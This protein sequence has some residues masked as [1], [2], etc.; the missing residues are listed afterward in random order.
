[1]N[2]YMEA[3]I[4]L[5]QNTDYADYSTQT[6]NIVNEALSI[7]QD[8]VEKSIPLKVDK[9]E[10]DIDNSD[11]RWTIR[12]YFCPKCGGNITIDNNYCSECGQHLDWS[13]N[14]E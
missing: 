12:I 8:W 5:I 3:F 4:N 13:E 1:M 11:S 9:N 7:I 6:Q 14:N 2:K 10:Y